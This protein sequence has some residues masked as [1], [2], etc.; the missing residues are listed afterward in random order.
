MGRDALP[1]DARADRFLVTLE[2][3]RR[4]A[5]LLRQ[6]GKQELAKQHDIL[7]KAIERRQRQKNGPIS[8]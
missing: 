7:A 5:E 6:S 8:V 2:R 1:R 4:Q 3:H